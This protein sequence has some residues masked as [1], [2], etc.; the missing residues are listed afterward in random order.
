MK[1][2]LILFLTFNFQLS[3][4]NFI[5]AQRKITTERIE[6]TNRLDANPDPKAMAIFERYKPAVDSLI[7]PVL[8]ESMVGMNA[9]RPESLL[10]NWAADML[11]E[12]SDLNDGQQA[13]LGIVNVGGLRNNMPQGVVRKGDIMLISPFNNRLAFITLKGSDLLELMQN[14]AARKGE[15]VSHEVKMVITKDGELVE[16]KVNREELLLIRKNMI[17]IMLFLI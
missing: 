9:G 1:K 16:V 14:I 12:Y 7:A 8:G 3:L 6:V 17:L 13:D 2:V 4:S 10:S 11:M 5:S 15:G